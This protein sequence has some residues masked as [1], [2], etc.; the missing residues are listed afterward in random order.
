MK[1]VA[2]K[3]AVDRARIKK[4][5]ELA[6]GKYN[7]LVPQAEVDA[8]LN[9][10]TP[11][12]WYRKQ[13]GKGVLR[14]W[15]DRTDAAHTYIQPVSDKMANVIVGYAEDYARKKNYPAYRVTA[16]QKATVDFVKSCKD[17]RIH[18]SGLVAWM[19][20]NF[21]A[22]STKEGTVNQDKR[23][24]SAI[25]GYVKKGRLVRVTTLTG[26]LIMHPSAC[27]KPEQTC[28]KVEYRKPEQLPLFSPEQLR[29][30]GEDHVSNEILVK[31]IKEV[32]AARVE[33]NKV[34]SMLETDRARMG[35]ASMAFAKTFSGR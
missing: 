14:R 35:A 12:S 16:K 21:K 18:L 29:S 3:G 17:G 19:K 7:G 20:D 26:I 30:S 22:Q 4:I 28:A 23:M 2:K 11:M 10:K 1:K 25:D 32:Q 9:L 34:M 8:I 15:V 6:K 5:K 31:L 24:V 27:S 33:I 13:A